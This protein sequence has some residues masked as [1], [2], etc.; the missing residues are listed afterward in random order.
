[1]NPFT[2]NHSLKIIHVIVNY[3]GIKKFRYE[4]PY[5][6]KLYVS[7]KNVINH[8]NGNYCRGPDWIDPEKKHRMAQSFAVSQY[9]IK[10]QTKRA[11]A[12]LGMM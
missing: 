8:L 12:K 5:C 1:M 11:R 9:I 10:L 6:P 4:C 2:Y 7:E 3:N